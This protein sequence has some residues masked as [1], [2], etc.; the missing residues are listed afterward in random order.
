MSNPKPRRRRIL[1]VDDNADI[2]LGMRV[3]LEALGQQVE[4]AGLVIIA[5]S[6]WGDDNA[7]TSSAA[8]G[9]DLHWLKPIAIDELMAY[10]SKTGPGN[11]RAPTAML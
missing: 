6:G 7:R 10:L 8:A 9:F 11:I 1:V 2:T 4:V 5:L 3:L